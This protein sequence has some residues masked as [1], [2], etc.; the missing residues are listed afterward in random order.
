M[1]FLRII[2]N[3]LLLHPLRF[4]IRYLLFQIYLRKF[5]K[6]QPYKGLISKNK[7][8]LSSSI[9][10]KSLKLLDKNYNNFK[11]S[12]EIIINDSNVEAFNEIFNKLRKSI[13]EYIGPNCKIDGMFYLASKPS[14]KSISSNWHTDNVGSRLKAFICLRGDGSQP[15]FLLPPSEEIFSIGYFFKVYFMEIIRWFGF[16]Y[17][18]NIKRTI[19][20]PHNRSTIFLFDTAILHRGGYECGTNE[21]LVLVIEFSN[22]HKH[23]ILSKGF[24]KGPIGSNE[25]NQFKIDNNSEISKD[26]SS[27][28]D[29]KKL[30]KENGF[31][32]Y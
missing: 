19:K 17:Q 21:R 6:R 9:S 13:I 27:L 8:W 7:G 5:E 20:M 10:K 3:L 32:H 28:L 16:N 29:S 30:K 15:T 26:F 14:F 24:L 25:K 22:P 12:N 31:L 2:K 23:K 11:L 18:I 1:N 4:T